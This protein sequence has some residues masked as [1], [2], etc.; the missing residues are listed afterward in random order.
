MKRLLYISPNGY[1][2]GAEKFLLTVCSGHARNK[3]VEA[4]LLFL[5]DGEAVIEAERLN[6][7]YRV[8]SHRFK[9]SSP[10]KL[11]RAL[12]EIRRLITE[13]RP[14]IIH[15]T[16][17]YAHIVIG[18]ACI[19]WNIKKVWFQ[20]GPVG[21]KLDKLASL[22]PCD[23]ILYNSLELQNQHHNTS[24]L[25][26]TR[27]EFV[28][29]LGVESSPLLRNILQGG[30]I[31]FGTSGRICSWKGYHNIIQALGEL[32]QEKGLTNFTYKIAGSAKTDHDK[33][34]Q[35]ELVHL[36]SQY[37]LEKEVQFLD[38]IPDI[39]QFY[40]QI[41]VFIHASTIPEPFGLVV[42]EAMGSGCLVI[43]S[44]TGGVSEILKNLSTG[45]S[46]DSISKDA[47]TNLKNILRNFPDSLNS[48]NRYQEIAWSGQKLIQ[49]KFSVKNMVT[50][51]EDEYFLL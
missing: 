29:R 41:D 27:R 21:G 9:L 4:T 19:R 31:S 51:L 2:G 1:V 35:M 8:L 46:Y 20:H 25:I 6:I 17:P 50:Q 5:N 11:L 32:K 15:S 26:H 48:I 30:T 22:F 49:E 40:H 36:V 44:N 42:A 12:K 10:F 45:I 3:R 34:Y 37:K 43:G 23:L 13:L 28:L 47:V 7:S 39:Q 18:L 14:D 24:P 38:H 16:M 33:K